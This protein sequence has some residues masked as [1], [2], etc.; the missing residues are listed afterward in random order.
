MKKMNFLKL[1]IIVSFLLL[2]I[3]VFGQ[4]P[5]KLNFQAVI[6]N[7]QGS[8]I[9][10]A[11]VGVKVSILQGSMSGTVVYSES[12]T[13][14]TNENGIL[15]LEIGGGVPTSGTFSTINWGNGPFFLKTELD[16]QGNNNYVLTTTS[17][18]L[19]VPYSLYSNKSDSSRFALNSAH[20][21]S[22][23]STDTALFAINSNHSNHSLNADH[24][25]HA[26]YAD[27]VL[28]SIYTD[29][30]Q[31]VSHVDS[32][33]YSSNSGH[34]V[35]ADSVARE[36]VYLYLRKKATTQQIANSANVA[37]TDYDTNNSS[38]ITLDNST[39]TV[40]FNKSG[41]YMLHGGVTWLTNGVNGRKIL[42]FDCV[43]ANHPG[44]IANAEVANEA[45]RMSTSFI[46]YFN[47]GDTIKMMVF[48]NTT[49][50]S[51][52]PNPNYTFDETTLNI[53]RIR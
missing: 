38:G 5:Q 51:T 46:G 20:S 28:H 36:N 16:P 3:N 8:L 32:A 35:F 12:Q 41:V 48:Q 43:S 22:S 21:L 17:E 52:T 40:T 39:G 11:P 26:V 33:N 7:A 18:L 6:R 19:S 34:A 49:V 1:G 44:R 15:F 53:E 30:T 27:T 31:V 9:N 2:E 29:S 25:N 14:I 37:I 13:P 10:N 45:A 50:T 47:A 23:S 42:W 24:S 4:A